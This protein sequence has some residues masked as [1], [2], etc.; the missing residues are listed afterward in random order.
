M[1]NEER[2]MKKLLPRYD[3]FTLV[4]SSLRFEGIFECLDSFSEVKI[5][6]GQELIDACFDELAFFFAQFA[7]SRKQMAEAEAG[8]G[9]G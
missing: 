6:F 9:G 7:S 3:F 8:A 4:C 5:G 1:K 2:R